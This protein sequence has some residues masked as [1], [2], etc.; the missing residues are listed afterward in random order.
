MATVIS[1]SRTAV[2]VIILLIVG[3]CTWFTQGLRMSSSVAARPRVPAVYGYSIVAEFKHSPEAFTQGLEFDQ[4]CS[5][6]AGRGGVLCEDV[7]WE[8]TGL[9]GQSSLREVTLATGVVRRKKELAYKYFAEGVTKFKGRL[10]QITWKTNNMIITSAKNFSDSKTL[11]TP[12]MDGWGLCTDGKSLILSNSTAA[13]SWLDPNSLALQ[14]TV[15]VHDGNVSVP[16]INELEWINGEIWANVWQTECIARISPADGRVTGWIYLDG[17]TQRQRDAHPNA[18]L[19]VM[20]G[21][22]W[23]KKKKALYVTGKWWHTLYQI[24]IKPAPVSNLPAIRDACIPR[25]SSILL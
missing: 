17:L 16:W 3:T 5:T 15:T 25:D 19:D 18:Q 14:R 20:N 11:K 12:L 6:P 4:A 9:N 24:V 23:D 8:S 7:Y 13:L 10:Y 1:P 21:I 2:A 22:A